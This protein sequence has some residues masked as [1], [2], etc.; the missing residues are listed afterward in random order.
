MIKRADKGSCVVIW[1][2]NDY[3][4]GA[5]IQLN[6]QNVYKSVEFKDKILTE[7]AE[8]SNHFFKSLKASGILSKKDLQYFTYKYKKTTSLEKM[9]L[10]PKIHARLYDVSGRPVNSNCGAPTEKVSEFSDH[11]LKPVM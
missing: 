3:V 1:D 4:N 6:N 7:L 10:L 2:R 5:E 8:K 11:H 9:Y